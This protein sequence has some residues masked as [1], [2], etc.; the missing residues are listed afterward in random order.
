MKLSVEE[1]STVLQNSTT[2]SIFHD[3][4]HGKHFSGGGTSEGKGNSKPGPFS[5]RK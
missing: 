2:A 4:L 3:A 5:K 1:L